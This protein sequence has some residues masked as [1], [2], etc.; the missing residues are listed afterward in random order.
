LSIFDTS[1]AEITR[2]VW[3]DAPWYAAKALQRPDDVIEIV[4]RG[5]EQ[6]DRAAA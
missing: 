3:L 4:M 6:E 5:E 1:L 2:D